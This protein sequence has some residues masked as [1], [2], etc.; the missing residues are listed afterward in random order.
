MCKKQLNKKVDK[1]KEKSY[2]K[3]MK[4]KKLRSPNLYKKSIFQLHQAWSQFKAKRART[5][6]WLDEDDENYLS[7]NERE[8]LID[9]LFKRLSN[10]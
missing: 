4:T 3:I 5:C 8:E 2:R 7:V 6:G 1:I 10:V 9:I